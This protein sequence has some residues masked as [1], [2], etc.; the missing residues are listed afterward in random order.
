MIAYRSANNLLISDIWVLNVSHFLL[1]EIN[2]CAQVEENVWKG[3]QF[4]RFLI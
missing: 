1:I 4:N 2:V 3:K